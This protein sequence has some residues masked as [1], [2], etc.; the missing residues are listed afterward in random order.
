MTSHYPRLPW[1]DLDGILLL[2][3]PRGPSS[4]QALQAAR[5]LL[6]AAKGGHTGSLDPLASGMLP[7]CLGEA[8][9]I[10]GLLLGARKAYEAV[11]KL[12]VV[13]DSGDADGRTIEVRPVPALDPAAVE[14]ALAP[15]RGRIRQRPPAY[16]ALKQGGE[17]LYRKA[18]RGEAVQVPEREVE[19]FALD[20]VERGADWLR[21]RIECG[22]GTYVR[23]LVGD[24]GQALGC[25][26]HV[27]ALRRLWVEP[28]RDCP[29]I[30]L[31]RLEAM[32]MAER[33]ACLLPI[34]AGLGGFPAC[35]LAPEPARRFAQGQAV[36][37][38]A[39]AHALDESAAPVVAYDMQGLALGLGQ[40]DPTRVLRPL[41]VFNVR[42]PPQ[43]TG[44]PWPGVQ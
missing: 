17:A 14:S 15:L 1:R 41:R 9:K 37:L 19:V 20:L 38:P 7:L 4:N 42:V 5:R 27:S 34:E 2:D 29:M 10:A 43:K 23:S 31:D 39:G 18:R 40:T 25:G 26:A 30:A 8:T 6:A 16:S 32:P 21:L 13:T 33:E 28:F 11:A 44:H 36:P 22:S 3:K 35:T 24:L 12:G